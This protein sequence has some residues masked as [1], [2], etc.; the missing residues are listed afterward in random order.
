MVSKKIKIRTN[1]PDCVLIFDPEKDFFHELNSSA[2]ELFIMIQKKI[3]EEKI[4]A[5]LISNYDI[6][7]KDAAKYLKSLIKNLVKLGIVSIKNQ[8]K[9]HE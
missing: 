7:E 5:H 3:S 1:Q 9:K 6:S 4:I 2:S 8:N